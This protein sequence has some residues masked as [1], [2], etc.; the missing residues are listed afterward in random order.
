MNIAIVNKWEVQGGAARAANRLRIALR[1][2]GHDVGYFVETPP[3]PAKKIFRPDYPKEPYKA[4]LEGLVQKEYIDRNRTDVSNTFFS[5]SY[6]DADIG[7]QP[8][9]LQCDIINLHWIDKMVSPKVLAT[10]VNLGKPL[11]WT[12]HD[13]KP[14]T[15]GCH[16]NAGCREFEAECLQCAQLANDPHRLPHHVL[17][18]KAAILEDADLTIVSPSRWLAEEAKK[19]A[20]FGGRR[21]EVIPN[22][23][24]TEVFKPENKREA[25]R[26]LEI[27]PDKIVIQFG[28]QDAREKR[29]GFEYLME[30]MHAALQVPAFRALCD[31]GKVLILCLGHPSPEIDRLPIE[32]RRLGF[33]SKDEAIVEAYNATDVFVLPTLEDNLPNTMLESLACATPVVAFD[34]GGVPDVVLHDENGLVVPRKDTQALAEAIV[35]LVTDDTK[36]QRFGENGRKLIEAEYTLSHQAKRYGT[37]FESL[38]DAGKNSTAQ[39]R[40]ATFTEEVFD[41][42]FGYVVRKELETSPGFIGPRPNRKREAQ[43][44][45]CIEEVCRYSI[46]RKPLDKYRAYK[47]LIKTYHAVK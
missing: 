26:R 47:K 29:K 11:V 20:L 34:T 38:L 37:L 5:F 8:A 25:K 39:R 32:S 23:I 3:K 33:L 44:I 30:A 27:D 7:H 24:E 22:A 28:A 16:Y 18:E 19:S 31:A 46:A 21:I 42:L 15:G 4:K 9:L 36:R 1:E 45:D 35:S 40:T 41:A 17:R 12:L 2:D 13:M 43:L 10:I 14:F 6:S